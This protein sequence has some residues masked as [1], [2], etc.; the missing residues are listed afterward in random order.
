MLYFI[1]RNHQK[2]YFNISR[3]VRSIFTSQQCVSVVCFLF[4]Q[5][6]PLSNILP[7]AAD[8]RFRVSVHPYYPPP[9]YIL[10]GEGRE[11]RHN[12]KYGMSSTSSLCSSFLSLFTVFDKNL[13]IF[14]HKYFGPFAHNP[15]TIKYKPKN[16]IRITKS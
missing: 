4:A 11:R 6:Q 8:A 14:L 3:R 7:A 5:P 10:K 15:I 2:I 16:H 1:I 13:E 12:S 9:V